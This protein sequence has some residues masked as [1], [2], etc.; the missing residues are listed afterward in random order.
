EAI[1][2]IARGFLVIWLVIWTIGGVMAGY[3]FLWMLYGKEV[4]RVGTGVFTIEH[5]LLSWNR[6]KDYDISSI[7]NLRVNDLLI[8]PGVKHPNY[9]F[10]RRRVIPGSF[11]FD[12]GYKTIT[13]GQ[14]VDLAEAH[15]LLDH[16]KNSPRLKEENF[17]TDS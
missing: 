4:I 13:F 3:Q 6:K 7:H 15:H 10:R 8:E 11:A 9:R 17:A 2:D 1:E 14:E 12:Y 5:Q 16:L